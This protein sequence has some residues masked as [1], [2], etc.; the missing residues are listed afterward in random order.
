MTPR[1]MSFD[2]RFS[3]VYDRITSE[4]FLSGTGIG[5]EIPFYIF[6]YPPEDE[7][8]LRDLLTR[9]TDRIEQNSP[10][11]HVHHVDLYALMMDCLEERNLLSR[12]LELEERK[13]SAAVLKALKAPL[14]AE[15]IA[16]ALVKQIPENC[17]LALMSGVGK[18]WPLIR[19][20]GLLSN[21]HPK[22]PPIPLVVFYP[23]GYD[24]QQLRLFRK[25]SS[26]S[27]YRAFRLIS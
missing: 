14:D 22:M 11:A 9:L 16:E 17:G 20:H 13:G 24:G 5:A 1:E 26:E 4:T 7:L 3:Q 12:A 18:S 6:D 21:L 19:T 8:R 2:E 25:M 15:R 27:Y 23:G 10:S